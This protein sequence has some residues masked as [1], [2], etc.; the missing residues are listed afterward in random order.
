MMVMDHPPEDHV[1]PP[2][3]FGLSPDETARAEAVAA[4]ARQREARREADRLR[5][6]QQAADRREDRPAAAAAEDGAPGG[7]GDEPDPNANDPLYR[8]MEEQVWAK[9]EILGD[10]TTAALGEV[11]RVSKTQQIKYDE[12]DPLPDWTNWMKPQNPIVPGRDQVRVFSQTNM[13]QFG[14]QFTEQDFQDARQ[15]MISKILESVQT[16]QTP[17]KRLVL[18]LEL[19][20]VKFR[21]KA[22]YKQTLMALSL[23]CARERR[24]HDLP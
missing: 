9:L 3:D 5:E 11:E 16:S 2:R 12:T 17:V 22:T 13:A 1:L 8:A 21:G 14:L 24:I 10:A 6:E 7:G 23:C 15:A 20:G 4:A 18:L 19:Y